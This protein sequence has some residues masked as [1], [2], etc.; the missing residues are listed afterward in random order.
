MANLA[1]V[2]ILFENEVQAESALVITEMYGRTG[3]SATRMTGRTPPR[4][5]L[6]DNDGVFVC[7]KR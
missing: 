6:R 1:S 4:F 2:R 7:S 5:L 3:M